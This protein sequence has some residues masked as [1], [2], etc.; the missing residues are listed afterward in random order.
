[1]ANSSKERSVCVVMKKEHLERNRVIFR[2][3]L[4]E[5]VRYAR[6]SHY[7]ESAGALQEAG[8][9]LLDLNTDLVGD[10]RPHLY[11][12]AL[13]QMAQRYISATAIVER[14][15]RGKGLQVAPNESLPATTERVA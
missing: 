13:R 15:K 12:P 8:K 1:M 4:L 5:A 9:I 6:N 10:P 3:D 7:S 2:Q 11:G 14:Y